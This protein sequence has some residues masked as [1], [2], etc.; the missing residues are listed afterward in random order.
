MKRNHE[1]LNKAVESK[2]DLGQEIIGAFLSA[3]FHKDDEWRKLADD[4][5]EACRRVKEAISGLR[6]EA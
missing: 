6:E 5:R 2:H 4:Y 3:T 1:V